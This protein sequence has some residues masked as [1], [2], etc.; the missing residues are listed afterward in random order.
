MKMEN[1]FKQI[2]HKLYEE[3]DLVGME[4]E[5]DEEDADVE[6]L[7]KEWKNVHIT[8][9]IWNFKKYENLIKI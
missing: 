5:S 7:D 2:V 3:L 1:D 6:T 9:I 8:L 4:S